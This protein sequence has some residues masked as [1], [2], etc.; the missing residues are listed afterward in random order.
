MSIVKLDFLK[1]YIALCPVL[2]YNRRK[3]GETNA[4]R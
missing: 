4:G 3:G 2:M 1:I